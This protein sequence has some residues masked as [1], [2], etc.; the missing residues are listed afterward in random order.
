MKLER[1]GPIGILTV[2]TVR[3]NAINLDFIH[4]AHAL[5]DEAEQDG[6]IR[7]LVVT[8]THRSLFCPGVDLPSLMGK[9]RGEMRAFYEALTGIVR[10]KFGYPKPEVYALNGHAVAGGFMMALAGEHRVMAQGP[11][12]VGL[13]E[14]ELGLTAPIGVVAMLEHVLG[15]RLAERVLFRGERYTA[16]QALALGLV[17]E[18]VE[19]DRLMDR[20]L[21]HARLLGSKPGAGY[22]RLKHYARHAVVERMAA[23]DAGQLDDLVDRWF[24]EDTQKLV[25]TAVERMTSG[26]TA[27]A[28]GRGTA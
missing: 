22:R 19:R 20:A 17:D 27:E 18:L 28:K 14:I 11:F 25:R 6:E 12:Y 16:E 1:E 15:G 24:A 3:S 4:E 21:E 26:K 23:L 10:R 13:M 9:S 5:M 2:D 7:A 8:S